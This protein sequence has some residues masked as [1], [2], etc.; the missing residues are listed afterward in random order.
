ME[1]RLR[2]HGGIPTIP[3]VPPHSG[4]WKASPLTARN[5]GGGIQSGAGTTATPKGPTAGQ[6]HTNMD[7][8][9]YLIH[10]GD[11]KAEY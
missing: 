10:C 9:F 2:Q 1:P 8:V 4:D 5:P 3:T 7:K 6:G 11:G